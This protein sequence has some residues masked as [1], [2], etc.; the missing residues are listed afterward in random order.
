MTSQP[1]APRPQHS[2]ELLE[3]TS[4]LFGTNAAYIEALY[5]QYLENPDAVDETWR[6]YFAS[7]EQQDLSPAQVGRGPEWKRDAQP[8]LA[9]SEIVGALT[10]QWPDKPSGLNE[11]D[12]RNAT[13]KSIRAIQ[14][15]RAF[16]VIGHL[17]ADLD[18]LK[19]NP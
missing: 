9:S 17:G 12:I 19:L 10:G 5:A 18:P 6:D 11:S 16:R 15:V 1:I 3:R 7:L 4:F 2:N 8:P 14:M 13:H